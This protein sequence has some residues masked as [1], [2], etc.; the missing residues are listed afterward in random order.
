MASLRLG[1]HHCSGYRF[2][3]MVL[4][5]YSEIIGG[6]VLYYDIWAPA[7]RRGRAGQRVGC[8]SLSSPAIGPAGISAYRRHGR[9]TVSRPGPAP[10]Q[11]EGGY[12]CQWTL[13]LDF[14]V[15]VWPGLRPS[16]A[17]KAAGA[18]HC[19]SRLDL[20]RPGRGH[21]QGALPPS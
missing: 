2:G 9:G 8:P 7:P 16:A 4:K 12:P 10:A 15:S 19:T 11:A 21:W 3:T 1:S 14:G 18:G 17:R 6:S 13:K 20:D 5:P